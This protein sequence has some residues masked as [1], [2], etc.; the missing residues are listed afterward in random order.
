[1]GSDTNVTERV[2]NQLLTEMDGI[3]DM[4]DIVVIAA[5]NR[6]DMMDPALL[7]PG[8]FDRLVLAPIPDVESRAEIFRVHTKEMPIDYKTLPK[9]Y[10]PTT[11]AVLIQ[12]FVAQEQNEDSKKKSQKTLSREEST[13]LLYLAEK[14]DGYVGADIESVCRE[15]AI[16]ALREDFNAKTVQLKHFEDALNKVPPSVTK[17]IQEGY[18]QIR[19]TFQAARAKELKEEKPS[20]IG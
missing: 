17:D 13:F 18:E 7:R 15:A 12:K 5:T 8:R 20:F 14:T 11:D 1:M 3:E 2:V 4:Y 16:L 10:T 9:D 19:E 6:P